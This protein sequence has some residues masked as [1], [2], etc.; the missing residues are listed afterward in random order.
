MPSGQ[1]LAV[2]FDDPKQV[3]VL[4]VPP[5]AFT[6][7]FGEKPQPGDELT[8]ARVRVQEG[9]QSAKHF[10]LCRRHHHATPECRWDR[11]AMCCRIASS[12]CSSSM[13]QIAS[14]VGATAR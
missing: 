11:S 7:V 1:V 13:S 2:A 6:H 9:S 10:L 12:S 4:D 5:A 3:L 14:T 8:N